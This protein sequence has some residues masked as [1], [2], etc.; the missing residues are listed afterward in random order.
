M[1]PE[2]MATSSQRSEAAE[3]IS[4]GA[5]VNAEGVSVDKV[6]CSTRLW[7]DQCARSRHIAIVSQQ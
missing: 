3:L 1:Y 5:I 4:Y 7:N 6:L 2:D